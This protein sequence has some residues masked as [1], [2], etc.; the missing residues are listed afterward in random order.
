MNVKNKRYSRQAKT[1]VPLATLI[2]SM[3]LPLLFGDSMVFD[4]NTTVDQEPEDGFGVPGPGTG[5]GD[6]DVT[7]PPGIEESIVL[8]PEYVDSVLSDNSHDFHMEDMVY[9]YSVLDEVY[10]L[11]MVGYQWQGSTNS[12]NTTWRVVYYEIDVSGASPQFV[13]RG[14]HTPSSS[15]YTYTNNSAFSSVVLADFDEDGIPELMCGGNVTYGGRVYSYY[16]RM[17][18]RNAVP[19]LTLLEEWD[20]T[21]SSSWNSTVIKLAAGDVDGDGHVDLISSNPAWLSTSHRN[22]IYVFPWLYFGI[23]NSLLNRQGYDNGWN[24]LRW[25]DIEIVSLDDDTYKE[26][27]LGGWVKETSFSDSYAA[28]S[29]LNYDGSG[30]LYV[31]SFKELEK[32]PELVKE[33]TMNEY[34]MGVDP[35]GIDGWITSVDRDTDVRTKRK[36]VDHFEVIELSDNDPTYNAQL[37]NEFSG[38]DECK[39]EFEIAW[40][41]PSSYHYIY[42]Y[43]GED[44]KIVLSTSGGIFQAYNYSSGSYVNLFTVEKARWYSISIV[45]D[46]YASTNGEYSVFVNSHLKGDAFGCYPSTDDDLDKIGFDTYGDF[47][48]NFM[49]VDDLRIYDMDGYDSAEVSSLDINDLNHDGKDD[50][51]ASV[52]HYSSLTGNYSTQL[53][54]FT[55]YIPEI[56]EDFEVYPSNMDI[57]GNGRWASNNNWAAGTNVIDDGTGSQV[58]ELRDTST[59]EIAQAWWELPGVVPDEGSISFMFKANDT[60]KPTF[61]YVAEG[62]S[63]EVNVPT[64]TPSAYCRVLVYQNYW[65]VYDSL[66]QVNTT[67][68][69]LSNTW[70]DVAIHY[71]IG[72]GWYLEV[73]SN[74]YGSGYTVSFYGT[75]GSFDHFEIKTLMSYKHY[76]CSIDDL[77]I[78]WEVFDLQNEHMHNWYMDG[79]VNIQERDDV[80]G[81]VL[82][83]KRNGG[84]P[85][86]DLGSTTQ[87]MTYGY[88]E[89]VIGSVSFWAKTEVDTM[90]NFQLCDLYQHPYPAHPGFFRLF[91]GTDMYIKQ[92]WTDTSSVSSGVRWTNGIWHEIRLD[93]YNIGI[94]GNAFVNVTYDGNQIF[95]ARRY[96]YNYQS[97]N[98]I[99]FSLS[100]DF[101]GTLLIDNLF[102]KLS[103]EPALNL[104]NIIDKSNTI[105]ASGDGVPRSTAITDIVASNPDEDPYSEVQ[106][107]V[108]Y[109]RNGLWT[110]G[111]HRVAY[112]EGKFEYEGDFETQLSSTTATSTKIVLGPQQWQRNRWAI[113]GG[114]YYYTGTNKFYYF[115]RLMVDETEKEDRLSLDLDDDVLYP[116]EIFND[117]SFRDYVDMET[118][119]VDRDG[120]EEII[121]L[122]NEPNNPSAPTILTIVKK[123]GNEYK[124][125]E[126]Q[127]F[128]PPSGVGMYMN[129]LLIKDIDGDGILE[130]LMAG[131]LFQTDPSTPWGLA[132]MLEYNEDYMFPGD[133]YFVANSIQGSTNPFIPSSFFRFTDPSSGLCYSVFNSIDAEDIDRDGIDEI[134]CGGYYLDAGVRRQGFAVFDFDGLSFVSVQEEVYKNRYPTI[135]GEIRAVKIFDLDDDGTYEVLLGG[136]STYFIAI[137]GPTEHADFRVYSVDSGFS[138]MARRM[139]VWKVYYSG[140]TSYFW[141]TYAIGSIPGYSSN[142]ASVINDI[143]LK[144]VDFDGKMDIITAGTYKYQPTSNNHRYGSTHIMGWNK[145][146]NDLDLLNY[147][148]FNDQ[149]NIRKTEFFDVA[150]DNIDYDDYSEL[151]LAGTSAVADDS[152]HDFLTVFQHNM[153]GTRYITS[154]EDYD[155]HYIDGIVINEICSGADSL[156]LYNYGSTQDLSGWTLEFYDNNGGPINTY[157]FPMGFTLNYNGYVVVYENTGTDTPTTLYTGFNIP[158]ANRPHALAL[159]DSS[160]TCVDWVEANYYTGPMP[161]GAIWED[162]YDLQMNSAF[163][164]RTTD[165][166]TDRA[167]DWVNSTIGSL[168]SANPGQSWVGAADYT[169]AVEIA[170]VDGDGVIEILSLVKSDEFGWNLYMYNKSKVVDDTD[171]E[172]ISLNDTINIIGSNL[173]L[174]YDDFEQD[175]S[176][177]DT[178]DGLWHITG[179]ES[180]WPDPYH[181]SNHSIWFGNETTGDY[182]TGQIENASIVT[183]PI[184]L[185]TTYQAYLSFYHWR[186]GE[187][188]S[189]DY[190]YVSVSTDGGYTWDNI[191][192]VNGVINPWSR[193]VLDLSSYCGNSS[194]QLE[195]RFDTR[196]GSANAYRGWLIDDI[197]VFTNESKYNLAIYLED[198]SEI[199]LQS[200]ATGAF[201]N[202]NIL[203][204]PWN[205]VETFDEP[206]RLT[207]EFS[208]NTSYLSPGV[209]RIT[210]IAND[211]HGNSQTLTVLV[212]ND[213]FTPVIELSKPL[214]G[215]MFNSTPS[216]NLTAFDEA[217]LDYGWYDVFVPSSNTTYG[218]YYIDSNSTMNA[219]VWN[220]IPVEQE[221]YWR[222]YVVDTAGNIGCSKV[223]IFKD[224][225]A[226][227]IIINA[228]FDSEVF[229]QPPDFNVTISDFAPDYSYYDV[230]VPSWGSATV[231]IEFT[232]NG[233]M[234]YDNIWNI[235]PDEELVEWRFFAEDV[236]GNIGMSS[237]F[238][239]KDTS[240]AEIK[241]SYVNVPTEVVLKQKGIS[242]EVFVENVGFNDA[243]VYGIDL[244][245]Y[246]GNV[247]NDRSNDYQIEELFT[248][249]Q[250][251]GAGGGYSFF[252]DVDVDRHA[253][254]NVTITIDARVFAYDDRTFDDISEMFSQ[255]PG[256]WFVLTSA[257]VVILDINDA[258]DSNTY[259]QGM[260]FTV[261]VTLEN[262]GYAK[263]TIDML[264]LQF[265]IGG[266]EAYGYSYTAPATFSIFGGQSIIVSIQVS[267]TD[268][269][270]IGE[271][272]IDVT[273]FGTEQYTDY[274]IF[275]HSNLTQPFYYNMGTDDDRANDIAYDE[276]YLYTVGSHY[277]L[278]ADHDVMVVMKWDVAGNV[279]W[280]WAWDTTYPS[281]GNGI[282]TDGDGIYAVGE[283]D[284]FG[285]GSQVLLVRLDTDGDEVWN[286]TWGGTGSENG[287]AI[288]AMNDALIIVGSTSSYGAGDSDLLVLAYYMNGTLF[289][290]DTWGGTDPDYGY[291]VSMDTSGI[292]ALGSTESFG[293]GSSRDA[294]IVKYDTANMTQLWN[295]TWGSTSTESAYSAGTSNNGTTLFVTGVTNGY[296]AGDDDIFLLS[297]STNG[298]YNWSRTWGGTENERGYIVGP[299]PDAVFV[300]GETNSFGNGGYDEVLIK[301]F[302]N[303]TEEWNRTYGTTGDDR[304]TSATGDQF[305]IYSCGFTDAYTPDNQVFITIQNQEEI[306]NTQIIMQ[307]R[308][309]VYVSNVFDLL[310]RGVY[311]EGE[312]FTVRVDYMNMGGTS[313][314]VDGTL[315]FGGYGHLTQMNP[316]SVWVLPNGTTSQIFT[317]TVMSGAYNYQ[318]DISVSM[319]CIENISGRS[320][321]LFEA[322]VLT[323]DIQSQ[324]DVV[325]TSIQDITAHAVYVAGETFT[326]RVHYSNTGGTDA[327]NID[328]LI[329]FNGYSWMA[330]DNPGPISISAGSTDYQDFLITIS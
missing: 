328:G 35:S 106:I 250:G 69:A 149:R 165:I 281:T 142:Y 115:L 238:I 137:N 199:S 41:N 162:D 79:N 191:Y 95:S 62:I 258:P 56:C 31:V 128:Y 54:L 260:S 108:N 30:N 194:V 139:A 314:E 179:A 317:V 302:I 129:D 239:E 167:S 97:V 143:E 53:L 110:P 109:L 259:V 72:T 170:D 21:Y 80:R 261:N 130:I 299:S 185:S 208:F 243:T 159:I 276:I 65:W 39:V 221:I 168:G 180:I 147:A 177:W 188:G 57:N 319:S 178:V 135:K 52:N 313:V 136:N 310:G 114:N 324:A 173:T 304:G 193:Q 232:E 83:L 322:D 49:Y 272:D 2:C 38:I 18:F 279:L 327:I 172:I 100:E 230:F 318:V 175:L 234:D 220:A 252:Y 12:T 200:N 297:L 37:T 183:T 28:T 241:I 224:L 278:T 42:A 48:N 150:V 74:T 25:N 85:E 251:I 158:W 202:L 160:G 255:S 13:Y 125:I 153:Q 81:S 36:F 176:K 29:V 11:V 215:E 256:E 264:D 325:I 226:P 1:L 140:A 294:L 63:D 266:V 312:S 182:E 126:N 218:G 16:R 253:F 59:T 166:D 268:D 22:I 196:D 86:A 27:V 190:S 267:T 146:S 273:G 210:F 113:L 271:V 203:G 257:H 222:F 45:Y 300:Y 92:N 288:L 133:D 73:G 293:N 6:G 77:A 90:A 82:V 227:S 242:I 107:A 323:L 277:N 326:I 121:L 308:G 71:K 93:I 214:D 274:A 195:F 228:P 78:S 120:V 104:F 219:V 98:N 321:G 141:N 89:R 118:A 197:R 233:T 40:S 204:A 320:F 311:V 286:T 291:G 9:G 247:T 207:V 4:I 316:A 290:N 112:R 181:S 152:G 296:G 51:V 174:F 58:L 306:N 212:Y 262:Q 117:A 231:T 265:T 282:W 151:V 102:V 50:V 240:I 236:A 269:C 275:F 145:S 103:P 134:I 66:S 211:I 47:S 161:P 309:D 26:I 225:S 61:L 148:I 303:G 283:T 292:Y 99:S 237:V 169:A 295:Y 229:S 5:D 17:Q 186:N 19:S 246:Y 187:G 76:T 216:F 189:Y 156:E 15:E 122:A 184:D 138:I 235:L 123:I 201:Q 301:F 205:S 254:A 217:E 206:W 34:E 7:S 285:F 298:T 94:V 329:I 44:L 116:L 157:S 192:Q 124:I 305:N 43:V 88:D 171:P 68:P 3:F 87:A 111:M 270:D 10:Y 249:S 14:M 84:D 287:E 144:D 289:L 155:Y 307:E 119:D 96:E 284:S 132:W 263:A 33:V 163:A 244:L 223:T 164:Y 23:H 127:Y 280:T 330:S 64:L 213:L 46:A 245:I 105:Q 91:V 131:A 75:P 24:N 32:E 60:Y 55:E 67:I 70:Y 20:Q 209:N 315:D 198:Q 154:V 101:V 8:E 248:L